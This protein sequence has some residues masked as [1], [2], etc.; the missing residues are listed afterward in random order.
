MPLHPEAIKRISITADSGE[1]YLIVAYRDD[2]NSAWLESP[3]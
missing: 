1:R 2:D 3:G